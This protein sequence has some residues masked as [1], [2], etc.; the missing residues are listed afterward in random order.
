MNDMSDVWIHIL[1]MNYRWNKNLG[2]GADW[3]HQVLAGHL[4]GLVG[5]GELG[6]IHKAL[7]TRGAVG[8]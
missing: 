2:L 8:V 6:W 4:N 5:F 3:V 1:Y 7:L